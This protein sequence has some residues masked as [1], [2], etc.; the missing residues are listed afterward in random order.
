[1]QYYRF[2]VI[3]EPEKEEGF[4]GAFNVS[5]PALPGCLTCGES[6]EEAR[7]MAKDAVACYVESLVQ[8][9]LP[10]PKDI[11]PKKVPAD[12][13]VEKMIVSVDH[14]VKVDPLTHELQMAGATFSPALWTPF[15]NKLV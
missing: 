4:A 14:L 5:V 9:N 3:L 1:M 2:T 11:K 15:L 8:D 7:F 12:S 13:L 10:V 6:L